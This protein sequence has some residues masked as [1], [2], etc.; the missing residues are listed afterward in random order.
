M[1]SKSLARHL[2][3]PDE[4][5]AAPADI[6]QPGFSSGNFFWPCWRVRHEVLPT[7][8]PSRRA[9]FIDLW[10]RQFPAGRDQVMTDVKQHVGECATYFPGCAQNVGVETTTK[11]RTATIED[12]VDRFG[13]AC[14]EALHAARH[15]VLVLCLYDEMDM[16]LLYRVVDDAESAASAA[17]REQLAKGPDEAAEA[18]PGNVAF[19]L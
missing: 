11:S 1:G 19:Y 15:E 6:Q 2:L 8:E 4:P 7:V 9:G 13:D 18:Q 12:A 3:E 16:V 5:V 17:C 10:R 14:A